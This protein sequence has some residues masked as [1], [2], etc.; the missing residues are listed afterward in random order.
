MAAPSSSCA[1]TSAS[2][3]GSPD[4]A[5]ITW[6]SRNSRSE[7]TPSS[8]EGPAHTSLPSHW[9]SSPQSA[10]RPPHTESSPSPAHCEPSAQNGS[11]ASGS[12]DEPTFTWQAPPSSVSSQSVP[13]G[14]GSS[15]AA[16]SQA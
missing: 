10:P 14:H 12:H 2:G 8:P 1:I 9:S 11:S 3:T 16:G 5:S 4:S 13:S 7:Q 15:S 6:P